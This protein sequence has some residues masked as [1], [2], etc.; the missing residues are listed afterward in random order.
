MISQQTIIDA[1]VSPDSILDLSLAKRSELLIVLRQQKMLA[2]VGKKLQT[3]NLFEQ[4]DQTSQRHFNNVL[5]IADK[6]L[7]L[8]DLELRHLQAALADHAEYALLLKGA[9]YAAL[10]NPVSEGRLFTD[11][12]ILVPK[13][14]LPNVEK[15][16]ALHGYIG[17]EIS[18]Y[19]DK[20]YRKWAHEIPPLAHGI[21]GTVLDVHHN[22]V[23]VV[24]R[25]AIAP[26]KLREQMEA[27]KH[28]FYV[29]SDAA[30]VVHSAIHLFRNEEYQTSFR[31]LTDLHIM[32]DGKPSEF[33]AC[34]MDIAQQWGMQYEVSL[35]FAM[36]QKLLDMP[37]PNEI[38]LVP[39]TRFDD[40]IFSSVLLPEHDLCDVQS[41]SKHTLAMIR[42]HIKK[43]P[44]P[45]LTY[46]LSV[47][48]GR[49]V[50]EGIFGEHLFTPAENEIKPAPD[51]QVSEQGHKK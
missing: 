23:P 26:E 41:P 49:S 21:R 34:V 32:L 4:L 31:D 19:D 47:K 5:T 36:L 29:L 22:L 40:F 51:R 30:Q 28:G 45:L 3:L 6:Q 2:R 48:A 9:A 27:G 15:I 11:I 39:I 16:L 10:N 44:L 35:A 1:Y 33:F 17:K 20:Y 50:L 7:A 14:D 46:H 37:L 8:V 25:A 13:S 18:D 42:G 43:M 38:D 12:D 24:S